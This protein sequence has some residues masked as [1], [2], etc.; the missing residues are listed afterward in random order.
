MQD[1]EWQDESLPNTIPSGATVE[2]DREEAQAA[3]R[4]DPVDEDALNA[5]PEGPV[6]PQVAE[7][8]KD[9]MELGASVKGEGEGQIVPPTPS[10]GE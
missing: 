8:E 9:S 7:A 2:A 6:D 10:S 1:T 3:H 4:A 5:A